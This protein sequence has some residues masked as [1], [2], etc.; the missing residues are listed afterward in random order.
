M[1][2]FLN[3]IINSLIL[4]ISYISNQNSFPKP[5]SAQEEA[6][7][8]RLMAEGNEDAKNKLI[9]H[10][11]RLVAHIAKKYSSAAQCQSDSEDLLSIGTIGLIKGINSFDASKGTRLAT[12][13][14]RCVENEIL[15]MLRSRKK[16]QNDVSL[17]DAIGTDK[18]GNTIML[19]DV[20]ENDESDIF[21]KIQTD[22][23][24]RKLYKNIKENLSDTE[25]KIIVLRY[26]LIDGRCLPQREIAEMLGISRSYVSRIEKKA[27]SK[28]GDGIRD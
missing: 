10:N 4:L 27:V 14:A 5:L 24:I 12:Y 17:S 13:A 9:E 2:A 26:G 3:S 19:M 28:L 11:L 15:M 18:E 25:R 20:I 6:E 22:D 16:S 21:D 1:L 7:C 8:L 23:S